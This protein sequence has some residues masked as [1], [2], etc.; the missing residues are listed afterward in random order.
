VTIKFSGL[1]NEALSRSSH[2]S[3]RQATVQGEE[4]FLK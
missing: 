1:C 3:G 4:D 2:R